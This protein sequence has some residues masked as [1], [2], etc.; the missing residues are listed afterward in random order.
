[1][2]DKDTILLTLKQLDNLD[3]VVI[4]PEDF[5]KTRSMQVTYDAK[6]CKFTAEQVHEEVINFITKALKDHEEIDVRKNNTI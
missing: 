2:E 5:D 4:I 1:M 6:D 3:V